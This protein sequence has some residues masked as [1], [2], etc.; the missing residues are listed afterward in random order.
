MA[1]RKLTTRLGLDE[2]VV[3]R[4]A[5]AGTTSVKDLFEQPEPQLMAILDRRCG[6]AHTAPS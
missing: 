3:R 1:T 6:Q 2:E 5:N 4:L